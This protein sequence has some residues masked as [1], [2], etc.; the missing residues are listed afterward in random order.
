MAVRQETTAKYRILLLEVYTKCQQGKRIDGLELCVRHKVHKGAMAAM[1]FLKILEETEERQ[2]FKWLPS[3]N[4]QGDLFIKLSHLIANRINDVAFERRTGKL[5]NKVQYSFDV[6]KTKKLITT[7]VTEED[8]V[9]SLNNL[10]AEE[11]L[12]RLKNPE[13][14]SE[15]TVYLEDVILSQEDTVLENLCLELSLTNARIL[16]AVLGDNKNPLL[17]AFCQDLTKSLLP[18]VY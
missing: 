3:Y 9:N 12:E 7:T 6:T 15:E 14:E 10:L 13:E 2:V 18:K 17:S 16:L 5:K 8:K 4:G 1:K 11:R